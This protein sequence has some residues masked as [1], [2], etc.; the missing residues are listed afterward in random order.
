[1]LCSAS[2]MIEVMY[3]LFGIF[4]G[5]ITVAISFILSLNS[6]DALVEV[7]WS[8]CMVYVIQSCKAATELTETAGSHHLVLYVRHKLTLTI[9]ILCHC[10]QEKSNI[11]ESPVAD[12]QKTL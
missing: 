10:V 9:G 1:M 8:L 2:W 5:L 4:A 11:C 12:F 6:P 7:L 3:I